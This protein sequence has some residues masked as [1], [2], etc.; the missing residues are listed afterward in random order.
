MYNFNLNLIKNSRKIELR[1][2]EMMLLRV[3]QKYD[4]ISKHFSKYH[5]KTNRKIPIIKLENGENLSLKNPESM[6]N[7]KEKYEIFLEELHN[8]NIAFFGLLPNLKKLTIRF[9]NISLLNENEF[10]EENRYQMLKEL[11]L[12]CNNLDSFFRNN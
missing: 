12:Y 11:N 4:I 5:S 10:C 6:Y 7:Y 9:S 2:D 8:C 1:K 3:K